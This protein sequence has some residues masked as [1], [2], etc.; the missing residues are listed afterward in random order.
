MAKITWF[1]H[2]AV[3]IEISGKI[4]FIDPMLTQNPASP[5]KASEITR[6]DV[7]FVTHD[8]PDHLGDAIDI[9]KQTGAIFVSVIELA[10]YVEQQGVKNVMKM[11]IGGI[12]TMGNV[13]L[14]IVQAVH[15]ASKGTPTGVVIQGE[16]LS[17]YHS[18]D[19]ALFG[20]MKIIGNQY[21]LDLACVSMGGNFTMDADQASEALSLL[22]PRMV[23]P[24][25]YGAFPLTAKDT[26]EFEEKVK[27]R[28]PEVQV[29]HLNPGDSY[30]LSKKKSK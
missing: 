15:S 24:I 23:L 20:D 6:A 2:S 17:I 1:G 9:C 11:N 26:T 8:H 30:E 29:L 18:G 27:V 12:W 4:I 13:K 22:K 28:T 25:H 21:S 7:I 14:T 3:K 5:L 16:G 19:T 10:N